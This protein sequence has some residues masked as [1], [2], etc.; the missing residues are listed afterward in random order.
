MLATLAKLDVPVLP[1]TSKTAAELEVLC[2]QLGLKSGYIAENGSLIHLF[3]PH[4]ARW[5]DQIT[6]TSLA[7]FTPLLDALASQ[8]KFQRLSQMS[9]DEVMSSTGL[10]KAD[11]ELAVQRQFSEGLLWQDSELNRSLLIEIVEKAGFQALQGGRFLSIMGQTDKG[12]ALDELR[13]QAERNQQHTPLIVALGDSENDLAMLHAA[14]I[15]V[16]I[17]NPTRTAPLD[18]EHADLIRTTRSGPAGWHEAMT[19]ILERYCDSPEQL[20][21]MAHNE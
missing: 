15:A 6:G 2:H 7:Q 19:Q 14:D 5:S 8:F 3:D 21:A 10:A 9:I 1:N 17:H 18:I 11:A 4:T 13:M 16:V 20:T 12:R